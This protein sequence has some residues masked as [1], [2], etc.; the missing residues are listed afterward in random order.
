MRRPTT[1]AKR[2]GDRGTALIE[3]S[4][5]AVLLMFFI[6][7]IAAFGLILAQKNSITQA[8][9]EGARS[10]LTVTDPTSAAATTKAIDT[11]KSTLNWMGT[12]RNDLTITA[13]I[14]ACDPPAAAPLCITVTVSYPYNAKPLIPAAP[15]L[16]LVTPDT[17]KAIAV[18]RVS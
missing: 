18:L 3:F 6:Y 16:G 5:V 12:K 14:G 17:I 10:A 2:S 7:A 8:A 9:T 4:L 15:G 1:L 13:P 11:V